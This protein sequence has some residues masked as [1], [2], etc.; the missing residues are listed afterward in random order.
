MWQAARH[1]GMASP[2]FVADMALSKARSLQ[3]SISKQAA[4]PQNLASPSKR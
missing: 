1:Y 3:I 4:T 2:R